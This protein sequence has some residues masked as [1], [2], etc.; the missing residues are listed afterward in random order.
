VL[1][2]VS[3]LYFE[4]DAGHGFRESRLVGYWFP[5]AVAYFRLR[6]SRKGPDQAKPSMP[7]GGSG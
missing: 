7:G 1:Y 6:L 2:D 3:T 4:T 5:A